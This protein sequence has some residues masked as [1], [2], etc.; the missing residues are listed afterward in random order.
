MPPSIPEFLRGVAAPGC[1]AEIPVAPASGI[2]QGSYE[3]YILRMN[4][5]EQDVMARYRADID[6]LLAPK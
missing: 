3:D 2:T 4:A 5:L 1:P 6:R